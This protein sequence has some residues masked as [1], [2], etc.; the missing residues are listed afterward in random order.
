M[1]KCPSVN[2]CISVQ[3]VAGLSALDSLD[4]LQ[5]PC[6]RVWDKAAYENAMFC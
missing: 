6:D 2:G 5:P 1:L 4:R 3:G